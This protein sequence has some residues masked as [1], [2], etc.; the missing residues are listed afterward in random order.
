MLRGLE[1][2]IDPCHAANLPCPYAGAIHHRVGNDPAERALHRADTAIR[3]LDGA[4]RA[5]LEYRHTGLAC[6]PRER[7]GNVGRIDA[8]ISREVESGSHVADIS[9]GPHT[10]HVRRTDLLT[11]DTPALCGAVAAAHLLGFCRSKSQLNR[12]ALDEAGRLAG[13]LFQ[14]AVELLGVGGKPR[15]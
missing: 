3:L 8:P 11:L 14:A 10:L 7:A 5:S 9:E 12:A 15:L 1:R 2:N 4:D 6:S 13:L